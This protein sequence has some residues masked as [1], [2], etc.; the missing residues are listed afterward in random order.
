LND[1]RKWCFGVFGIYGEIPDIEFEAVWLWRG[2]EIPQLMKD[3]DSY[4]YSEFRK[5][6]V[7]KPE[8]KK[9]IE[10]FWLNT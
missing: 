4:E 9:L 8:D 1:F 3:Q 2:V 7:N 10:E 5:L 6:D